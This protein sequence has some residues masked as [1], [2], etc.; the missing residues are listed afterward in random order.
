MKVFLNFTL[1]IL[2]AALGCAFQT[3]LWMQV[4]GTFSTPQMWIPFA[5]YWSLYRSPLEAVAM[6]YGLTILATSFSGVPFSVFLIALCGT[7]IALSFL[8][9]RILWGSATFFMLA[10]GG[11]SVAFPVLHLIV[12]W[13]VEERPIHRP[14]IFTWLLSVLLNMLLSLPLLRLFNWF[15]SLTHKE[16]PTEAGSELA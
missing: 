11:A 16:P 10:S 9:Q 3:S 8:K 12:S 4:F 15:D 14:E 5:V 2:S 13:I 7:H 6:I 1:F